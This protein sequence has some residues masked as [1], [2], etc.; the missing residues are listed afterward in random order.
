MDLR[1]PLAFIASRRPIRG[2]KAF[3][4]LAYFSRTLQMPINCSFSMYLYGPYSNEVAVEHSDMIASGLLLERDDNVLEKGASL[5]EYLKDHSREINDYSAQLEKLDKCFG[6][7][8]PWKLELYATTHFLA[9]SAKRIGKEF[10]EE[11]AVREVRKAKGGKF[12]SEE[13]GKA[14]RDL[15]A[16]ELF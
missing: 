7:M 6:S 11:D 9:T 14:F 13:I 16:W 10:E 1:L 2:K 12:R 15:E 4:K 5:E 3:Q 8:P